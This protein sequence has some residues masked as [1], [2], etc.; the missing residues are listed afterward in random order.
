MKWKTWQVGLTMVELM[1]ALALSATLAAA[2][3]RVFVA[4]QQSMQLA[5]S[6][7]Q[8]QEVA[9]TSFDVLRS[10]LRMLGYQGCVN[11]VSRVNNLLSTNPA[12]GYKP[13]IHNYQL[14]AEVVDNYQAGDVN[15]SDILPTGVE[16]VTGTDVIISRMARSIDLL[17]AV[18]E[19]SSHNNF[20]V[21]GNQ[22]SFLENMVSSSKNPVL[23]ISDCQDSNI[24]TVSAVETDGSTGRSKIVHD[25]A[26]ARGPNNSTWELSRIFAVGSQVLAMD[27]VIYFV[28][29][30]KDAQGDW[31]SYHSLYRYSSLESNADDTAYP[32][33]PYVE[34][35]QL[36]FTVDTDEDGA[37]DTYMTA[38]QIEADTD[39]YN[40]NTGGITKHIY[41]ITLSLV[42]ADRRSCGKPNASATSC[43]EP[44]N[45]LQTILI[46]NPRGDA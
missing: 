6:Y 24:F 35:M 17:V 4:N 16:V 28:G 45:Y 30:A 37:P 2:L 38:A 18:E 27:T 41:S 42:I 7:A 33:V 22:A 21:I 25:E 5:D 40:V 3:Y 31:E 26:I 14:P 39:L 8:I 10:D 11:D 12:G 44:Q 34:D 20:H 9:R 36:T 13:L 43:V 46:R 15:L 23:M 32:L 1:V 19:L 29:R